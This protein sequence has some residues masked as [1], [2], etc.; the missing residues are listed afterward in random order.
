MPDEWETEQ[1]LNINDASDRNSDNDEDGYT[2]LE[3]YLNS[4]VV[5]DH[6]IPTAIPNE[7]GSTELFNYQFIALSEKVS[8][9]LNLSARE[10]VTIELITLDGKRHPVVVDTQ[11]ES[12]SSSFNIDV[13][14]FINERII[15]LK[16]VV[17]KEI[18]CKKVVLY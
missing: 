16:V 10:R 6:D 15:V 13:S 4:L 5:E 12:G 8:V 14:K 2:N 3:E 18:S 9:N 7:L 17:D 11:F 1:G